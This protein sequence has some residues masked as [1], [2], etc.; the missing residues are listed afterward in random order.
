[1]DDV[2]LG[3]AF[4]AGLVSFF[5]PCIFPLVPAYLAHLTGTDVSAGEVHADR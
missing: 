2:S 1:M 4:M 3:I 5:S